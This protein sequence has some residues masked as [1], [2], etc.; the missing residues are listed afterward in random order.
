[1]NEVV[2]FTGVEEFMILCIAD[3][4]RN[5][6]PGEENGKGKSVTFTLPQNLNNGLANELYKSEHKN[7]DIV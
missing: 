7:S 5:P 3:T 2:F 1:M 4:T 6:R